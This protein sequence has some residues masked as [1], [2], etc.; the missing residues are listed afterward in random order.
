MT[1]MD[2]GNPYKHPGSGGATSRPPSG[3]EDWYP[4]N[5]VSWTVEYEDVPVEHCLTVS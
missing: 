2:H 1:R 5:N 3:G 4:P